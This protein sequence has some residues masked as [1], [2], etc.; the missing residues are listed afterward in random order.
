MKYLVILLLLLFL[1]AMIATRYRRQ[2]TM[3]IQIF[4]MFRKMRSASA[5]PQ[6]KQIQKKDDGG[7]VPLVKCVRCG[8]WVPK[9]NALSLGRSIYCSTVCVERSEVRV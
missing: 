2:I 9:S 7:A 4:Q 6:E 8:T 3:G 5:P 1:F